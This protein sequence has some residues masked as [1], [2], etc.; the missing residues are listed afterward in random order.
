M[1]FNRALNNNKVMFNY[2]V[3]LGQWLRGP[4]EIDCFNG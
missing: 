2:P 1:L 3:N 4:S